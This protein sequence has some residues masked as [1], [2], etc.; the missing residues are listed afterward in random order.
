MERVRQAPFH[1]PA[2]GDQRLADDL[3]SE[4]GLPTEVPG[5]ATEEVHLERLEVEQPE[6]I[7]E[8]GPNLGHGHLPAIPT[9]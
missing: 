9:P 6:Q 7:V 2:R 1:R 5:L 4:D 3:S 8:R